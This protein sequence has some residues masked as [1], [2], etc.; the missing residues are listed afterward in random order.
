MTPPMETKLIEEVAR[1]FVRCASLDPDDRRLDGEP[2][3][4]RY[5]DEAKAAIAT[6]RAHDAPHTQQVQLGTKLN[7]SDAKPTCKKCS[8][9]KMGAPDLCRCAK[10]ISG[11]HHVATLGKGEYA[12]ADPDNGM[13][14]A[15]TNEGT[16]SKVA[17]CGAH[18]A[19]PK[20]GDGINLADGLNA[21]KDAKPTGEMAVLPRGGRITPFDVYFEGVC[22][23]P[24]DV[25]SRL[26]IYHLREIWKHM[27]EPALTVAVHN[28]QKPEPVELIPVSDRDGVTICD[29]H[30]RAVRLPDGGLSDSVWIQHNSGEGGSFPAEPLADLIGRFYNERF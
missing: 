3:W 12:V 10:P 21:P 2:L 20:L 29:Y 14:I 7:V 24:E 4:T 28:S 5:V 27:V 6:I 11:A 22:S 23:L 15:N 19:K 16:L 18:D 30:V 26:S 8:Y 13:F 1:E 9:C 25:K 17:P